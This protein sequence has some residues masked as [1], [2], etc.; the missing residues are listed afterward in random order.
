MPGITPHKPHQH[1]AGDP[2]EFEPG[3]LPVEP[4]EGPFPA[5][6]PDDPE[7]EARPSSANR[8]RDWPSA[9]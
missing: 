8:H 7:H 5:G 6:V 9:P 3:S 1:D 4:D 2:D